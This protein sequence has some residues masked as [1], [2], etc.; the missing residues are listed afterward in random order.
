[1]R[2]RRVVLGGLVLVVLAGA[3]VA[4]VPRFR[5]E[6][7]RLAPAAGDR[8]GEA[9]AERPRTSEQ[10]IAAA[11]EAGDLTYEESLLARAYALFNDPRLE[12]AFR[13]P[14]VNWEA[15]TRLFDEIEREQPKLSA[16]LLAA[17]LPFRVRPSDPRSIVNQPRAEAVRASQIPDGEL[18][19]WVHRPVAG[20]NVHI[21]IKGTQ[22]DLDPYAPMVKSVWDT[23]PSFFPHPLPD[24]GPGPVSE[25]NR[26]PS[27]VNPDGAI[28][29]YFMRAGELDIRCSERAGPW[30]GCHMMRGTG[31][32]AG[33]AEARRDNATR[34]GRKSGYV[35][36]DTGQPSNEVLDA[37][38]H[39]ITHASQRQ[40][41][42]CEPAPFARTGRC[43]S[44]D[45]DLGP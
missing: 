14:E 24:D 12:P 5:G 3:I 31:G 2:S 8:P 38:A 28:D 18:E 26:D 39:E 7:A 45:H 42:A 4:L 35:M 21:W 30:R 9:V 6:L 22:A 23:L 32:V 20:T 43:D 29:V 44:E 41:C 16:E 15:G 33:I 10:L 17:L 36:V 27:Q 1:M 13:S 37:F 19:K 40:S 11:L 34:P 25:T